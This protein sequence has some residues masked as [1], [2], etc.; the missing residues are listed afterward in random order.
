MNKE[1]LDS[2]FHSKKI[3]SIAE[4]SI[5]SAVSISLFG[6][7]WVS[8]VGLPN[9]NL[10]LVDVL[11]FFGILCL[12]IFQKRNN[13]FKST[14][15]ITFLLALFITFQ[16]FRNV[17]YPLITRLRDLIPYLYLFCTAVIIKKFPMGAWIRT[18]RFLR[19]A[20]L[21]GAIWTDL[22][23][24][25]L[26]KEFYA[27]E[28]FAGV[29]IFSARW[30]HSGISLCIGLLLWGSFPK[31]NLKENVPIRLFLLTSTLLQYS[32]ASYVGLFFVLASIYF[33][34]KFG[35][36]KFTQKRDRFLKTCLVFFIIGIPTLT[37]IAP[38]IPERSALSRIG[39][40]NIFSPTKLIQ[41][42][43]DSGTANARIEA[44]KLLS[45]WLR[46]NHLEFLGAGPGREMV[47]ESNAYVF[48]SGA[49]DVRSPHSWLYGNLGRYGV[50]GLIFWHFL[51]FTY[52]RA[53][54]NKLRFFQFPENILMPI[55]VIALFGVVLESPFGILP[56]SFFLGSSHLSTL[57]SRE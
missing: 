54:K 56:F 35:K 20:T 4:N 12:A 50:L 53:Q 24:V 36:R 15:P 17:D 30:D 8:Y 21:L 49:R 38:I 41:D 11:F 18:I 7:R 34:T 47:L 55:Y 33:A 1:L 43:R 44:Q 45:N 5:I 28:Q 13:Q 39:V 40:E 19:V 48:L 51:C 14:F 6:G 31:A 32:R 16:M 37:L 27:P 29:P 22:V 23:M 2:K 10:F 3:I 57:S 42:M 46:R 52:L 25:G 9:Y 26:L